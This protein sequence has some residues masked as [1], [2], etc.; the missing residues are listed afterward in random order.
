MKGKGKITFLLIAVSVILIAVNAVVLLAEDRRAPEIS[1]PQD[2]LTYSER[3]DESL[4]LQGVTASDNREG[5][6]TDSLRIGEVLPSADGT[7]VT[8]VYIARDGSNNIAQASRILNIT[9]AAGTEN[10]Q[11]NN[12]GSAGGTQEDAVPSAEP[13]ATVTP[14]PTTTATP[15]PTVTTAPSDPDEAGRQENDAA[16]AALSPEAPRLYLSQYALNIPLNGDFNALSYVSDVT[17]DVDSRDTLFTRISIDGSVD[18][19]TEGTYELYFYANDTD[20]NVSNRARMVV[21]VQ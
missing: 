6:V 7:Q 12:A 13:T 11:E 8:V 19:Q 17:D 1:F 5:D 16:I 21:T 9:G 10:T 4:L 2:A 18:T 20:G 3:M 14:E 15:E